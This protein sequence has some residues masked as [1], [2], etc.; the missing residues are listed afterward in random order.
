MSGLFT[1]LPRLRSR[2]RSCSRRG[3]SDRHINGNSAFAANNLA[4]FL[5]GNSHGLSD[6]LRDTVCVKTG[7]IKCGV[8]LRH[9]YW[10]VHPAGLVNITEV[11]PGEYSEVSFTAESYPSAVAGPTVPGFT[12]V[13]IDV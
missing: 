5:A 13:T 6:K 1:L 10:L 4:Q 12:L 8:F 2:L 7:I 9:Q 3:H 11:Y